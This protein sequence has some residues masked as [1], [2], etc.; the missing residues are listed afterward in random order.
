M[1]GILNQFASIRKLKHLLDGDRPSNPAR[2]TVRPKLEQLEA[3]EVLSAPALSSGPPNPI[4]A[5]QQLLQLEA[6]PSG[7]LAPVLDNILSGVVAALP[8]ISS[9]LNAAS[10]DL[11]AIFGPKLG[12]QYMNVVI[13]VVDGFLINLENAT[14]SALHAGGDFQDPTFNADV[15]FINAFMFNPLNYVPPV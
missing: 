1:S 12:Q 5:Y 6:N 7:N 4:Q 11:N 3:R 13:R 8:G 15:A 10:S 2:T 14:L 9:L